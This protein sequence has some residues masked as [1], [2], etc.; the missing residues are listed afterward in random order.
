MYLKSIVLFL[1]NTSLYYTFYIFNID[2]FF[3]HLLPSLY[4]VQNLIFEIQNVILFASDLW[5]L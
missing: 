5:V 2:A 3:E 4:E 1:L